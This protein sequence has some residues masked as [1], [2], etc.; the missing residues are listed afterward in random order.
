MKEKLK[1]LMIANDLFSIINNRGIKATK[2]E[3]GGINLFQTTE[4]KSPEIIDNIK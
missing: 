1:T 4:N 2:S 3:I